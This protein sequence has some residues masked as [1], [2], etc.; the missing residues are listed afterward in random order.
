MGRDQPHVWE[1]KGCHGWEGQKASCRP[2]PAGGE[3]VRGRG[4]AFLARGTASAKDLRPGVTMGQRGGWCARTGGT[5]VRGWPGPA[6]WA[7]W[8]SG[9]GS[10]YST[11]ACGHTQAPHT[12]AAQKTFAESE[13]A[14]HRPSSALGAPGPSYLPSEAP[15][16]REFRPARAFLRTV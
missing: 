15:G 5:E 11:H 13:R 14:G 6:H 10:D 12:T 16:C 3:G 9:R 8:A 2:R 4:T 7:L 1:E